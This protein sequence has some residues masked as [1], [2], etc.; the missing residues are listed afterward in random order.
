MEPINARSMIAAAAATAAVAAPERPATE[1]RRRLSP[2][3]L[4]VTNQKVRAAYSPIVIAGV[5]RIVDFVMLSA[6]RRCALSRLC[7]A[8]QRLQLGIR[9]RHRGHDSHSG[10]MLPG[11]RHLSGADIPRPAPANDPDDLVLGLCVFA[12]HWCL[13]LRK[14]RQ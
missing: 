1:R 10:G 14:A 6:D 8:Q 7:S 3:A 4:A 12:V 11:L 5:T 2:A 9:R 13:L